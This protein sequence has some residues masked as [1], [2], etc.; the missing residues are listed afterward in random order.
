MQDLQEIRG[1]S[2]SIAV[3]RRTDSCLGDVTQGRAEGRRAQGGHA[4]AVRSALGGNS[5]APGGKSE[6]AGASSHCRQGGAGRPVFASQ[7]ARLISLRTND[8]SL[9]LSLGCAVHST[10]SSPNKSSALLTLLPFRVADSKAR[11]PP[12]APLTL[13]SS[14]PNSKPMQRSS[15]M[16]ESRRLSRQPHLT[17]EMLDS[18]R[19][20]NSGYTGSDPRAGGRWDPSGAHELGSARTLD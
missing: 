5:G 14:A 16:C 8:R 7:A 4:D 1:C 20:T 13:R 17:H 15:F 10:R 9:S 3:Y 18:H 6:R 19:C 11:P 2:S 12:L